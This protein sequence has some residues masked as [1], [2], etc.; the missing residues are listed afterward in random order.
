[1]PA[2]S[3]ILHNDK[4]IPY[5]YLQRRLVASASF[6][7]DKAGATVALKRT[8]QNLIDSDRLKELGKQWSNDKYGTSQR[9]FVVAD[10]GVLD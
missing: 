10:L 2:K 6:R 1:M 5:V 3:T 4:V 7:L 8:I 9:C